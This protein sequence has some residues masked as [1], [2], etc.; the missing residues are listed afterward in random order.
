MSRRRIAF[1]LSALVAW[2]AGMALG[3]FGAVSTRVAHAEPLLTLGKMNADFVPS[4]K[5]GKPVFVLFLGSDAREGE[6]VDGTRSDSIQLVA[7][8]PAKHRATVLGFPR[9]SWVDIPGHGTDKINSANSYGGPELMVETVEGLTGIAIDYYALTSFRGFTEM[10]N[11]IGGL[12]VDVPF[13]MVGGGADLPN[14]GPQRLSG[15][16]ALSF[17]RDR[18]SIPTGDFGRSENQGHLLIDALV[19]FR[20]EFAKNPSRLLTWVAWG[21]RGTNFTNLPLNEVL[22]LAFMATSISAKHVQGM[23]VPATTG[24]VGATSVVYIR[25]EAQAIY[26]DLASDGIVSAANV[27]PSY[28]QT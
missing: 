12:I 27:P 26:E 21:L 4:L 20:K 28:L 3:T 9:D 17:A 22:A 16:Q 7:I 23:V 18:H 11:G 8:N 25:S 2:N 1:V 15:S 19:Q 13:P 6:P 24:M 10:V 14:V 5:S